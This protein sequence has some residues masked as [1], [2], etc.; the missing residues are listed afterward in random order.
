MRSG[1]GGFVE[2][3]GETCEPEPLPRLPGELD[4]LFERRPFQWDKRQ[5]VQ[6]AHPRVLA[7]LSGQVYLVGTSLG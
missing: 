1:G 7:R 5:H 2:V 4:G 3:N 6:R